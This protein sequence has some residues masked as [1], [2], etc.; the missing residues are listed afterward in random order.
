MLLKKVNFLFLFFSMAGISVALAQY[1]QLKTS[2]ATVIAGQRF[3]ITYDASGTSLS[4]MSNVKGIAYYYADFGWHGT[5]LKMSPIEK[6]KWSATINTEKNW[7]LVAF[8]FMAGDSVD[9]NS[10]I[11]ASFLTPYAQFLRNPEDTARTAKGALA[12]WGLFRSSEY[13][14]E[15]PE[16]LKQGKFVSDT[17]V[18]MY[19]QKE[20]EQNHQ[21]EYKSAFAVPYATSMYRAYGGSSAPKVR[22]VLNY[23]TRQGAT[24]MDLLRA[25]QILKNTGQDLRADSLSNAIAIGYPDSYIAK[26]QAYKMFSAQKDQG[27]L[28]QLGEDFLAKFPYDRAYREFDKANGIDYN[29]VYLTVILL[30]IGNNDFK[31]IDKYIDQMSYLTLINVYYKTVQIAHHRKSVEDSY[32]Y[33]YSAL[34]LKRMQTIKSNIPEEYQYFSPDEW[35]NFFNNAYIAGYAPMV[36]EHI[37]ICRGAGK[38]EEGLAYAKEAET[39]QQYKKE[40]LNDDYVFL[41]NKTGHANEVNDVLIKSMYEN[42]VSVPMLDMIKQ[43]YI[44]KYKS[45]EGF[46]K[47]LQSLKNASASNLNKEELPIINKAMVNWTMTDLKG[48]K[49]SLAALKGKTVVMDFWATWCVP[50]KAS[51]PGMNLAVQRYKNDPSVVF[52][53]VDTEE[54][55]A[56][57]KQ[58]IQQYVKDNGYTFNVL[59]DNP[60]LKGKGTGEVFSRV[61]KA[62]QISGVPLKLII[63]KKGVVRYMTSGFKGSATELSDEISQLIEL[64][65]KQN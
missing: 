4:G 43:N 34:M 23:L 41:L 7:A 45:D 48:K 17:V 3:D 19:L 57:Y 8:K 63:D 1:K 15:I 28:R 56:D 18:S 13:G 35:L 58:Q 61:S 39:F 6:N 29:R 16:Y 5:D 10:G 47:Y 53:F 52:Y 33:P 62:F 11:K 64:T 2:P 25:W 24:Q 59:F 30:Q 51:L 21:Q 46:D 27:K 49:V 40:S 55:E 20:L 44:A 37:S 65:K 36:L 60:M 38:F 22:A 42:Q 12:V 32:L 26:L 50:C 54:T 31:V 14:F 9:T